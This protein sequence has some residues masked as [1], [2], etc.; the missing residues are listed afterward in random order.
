M[1]E[2]LIFGP[3]EVDMLEH[4]DEHEILARQIAYFSGDGAVEAMLRHLHDSP[5]VE[6]LHGVIAL[7]E[8][9]QRTREPF[10]ARDDLDPLF[11]DLMCGLMNFDLKTRLTVTEALAH[12]WFADVVN[13]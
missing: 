1:E 3:P 11:R 9:G 8:E 5:F 10:A 2:D 13:E 7:F 12:P 6:Q 4:W